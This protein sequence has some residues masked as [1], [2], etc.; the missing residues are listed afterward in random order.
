MLRNGLD[1]GV[2]VRRRFD[3]TVF[4]QRE[5]QELANR[6]G[7]LRYFVASQAGA[8]WE[9]A[10]REESRLIDTLRLAGTEL[11]QLESG[12]ARVQ[13]HVEELMDIEERLA[14][15]ADQGADSLIEE[16]TELAELDH[17]VNEVLAWPSTVSV[18]VDDLANTLPAPMLP[19]HR[20]I[21]TSLQ[22]QGAGLGTAVTQFVFKLRG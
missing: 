2:D 9:N 11:G 13:E 7:L 12:L 22:D 5:L 21:P 1:T 16:S 18:A 14:R 15:A 3:V 20:L 6:E 8:E 17:A 4:G 10:M 19:N